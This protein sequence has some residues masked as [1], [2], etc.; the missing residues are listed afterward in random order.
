MLKQNKCTACHGMTKKIVGP[1]F[2]EITA[3][4]KGDPNAEAHLIDVVANGGSGVWGGTMPPHG[5]IKAEY[6]KTMVQTILT[7]AK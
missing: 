7:G 1:G 3:K 4:Y 5:H 6:I 2:A